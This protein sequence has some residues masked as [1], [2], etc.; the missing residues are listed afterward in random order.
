[1]L[2]RRRGGGGV[3]KK[4]VQIKTAKKQIFGIKLT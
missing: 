2:G 4:G 1:M 3:G